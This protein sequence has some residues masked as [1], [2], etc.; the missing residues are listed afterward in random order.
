MNTSSPVLSSLS[1][2]ADEKADVIL[3]DPY[4][5]QQQAED[6]QVDNRVGVASTPPGFYLG[7]DTLDTSVILTFS[8]VSPS[9]HLL[10]CPHFPY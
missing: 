8:G 4:P 3:L 5:S 10:F 7:L 6:H 2:G 1:N 9:S